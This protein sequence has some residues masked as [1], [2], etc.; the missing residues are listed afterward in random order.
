MSVNFW[1]LYKWQSF[2]ISD[3]LSCTIHSRSKWKSWDRASEDLVLHSLSL[4]NMANLTHKP[5]SHLKSLHPCCIHSKPH[6][7]LTDITSPEQ[8][9]C[10]RSHQKRDAVTM[11]VAV[12]MVVVVL[13]LLNGTKIGNGSTVLLRAHK[14]KLF[15]CRKPF[16]Q[17]LILL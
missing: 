2:V 5:W 7:N 16:T 14:C 11:V 13:L 9:L 12:V 6:W 17:F 8:I 15:Q 3:F 1:P 4:I 10:S